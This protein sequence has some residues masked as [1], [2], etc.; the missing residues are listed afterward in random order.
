MVSEPGKETTFSIYLPATREPVEKK[1]EEEEEK[2]EIDSRVQKK[3]VLVMDDEDSI[4]ELT[5]HA[6]SLLG[7]SVEFAREGAEAVEHYKKAK[8]DGEPFDVVLMDL[9]IPGGMGGKETIKELIKVDPSV[10]AVVSSGCSEDPVMADPKRF[11]FLNVLA[12]PYQITDLRKVLID[13]IKHT[14]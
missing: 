1:K 2:L 4:R 11:G 10:K 9:T 8:K 5:G 12:R 14:P 3:K 13:V 7:Y 6:L